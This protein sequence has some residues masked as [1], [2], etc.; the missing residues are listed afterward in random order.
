MEKLLAIITSPLDLKGLS[1]PQLLRAE[2]LSMLMDGI[3]LHGARM[4][5]WYER[6]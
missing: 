6:E 2:A 3:D 5:S 1:L 4:R